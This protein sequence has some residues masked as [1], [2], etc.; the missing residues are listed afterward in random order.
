MKSWLIAL[1][2]LIPSCA[3]AQ[4]QWEHNGSIVTLR[5]DGTER[6]F[7]YSSPRSGLPVTAGTLLFK[8]K[9]D[10]DSYSGTAYSFSSRCRPI[11]YTVSGSVSSDQRTVTM[12]GKIPR[13]DGSCRTV[14]YDDDVLVF[15]FH[16]SNANVAYTP[17]SNLSNNRSS[18]STIG[19]EE[20]VVVCTVPVPIA[21]KNLGTLAQSR[22]SVRA[23]AQA[24]IDHL[25]AS[26]C[27]EIDA[28]PTSD[29]AEVVELN[30][31]CNQVSG[32]LN[33]ERVYWVY[34]LAYGQGE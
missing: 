30:E 7:V 21:I 10:G 9:K 29:G 15:S 16:D 20:R 12:Y 22:P 19:G 23:V 33:G 32:R 24:E 1:Y 6:S 25:L 26:Y 2:V 5:A 8:G 34:C 4:S 11:G 13:R 17:N 14:K 31:N 3:F 28:A 27:R 18:E